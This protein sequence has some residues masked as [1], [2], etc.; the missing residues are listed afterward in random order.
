M[1]EYYCVECEKKWNQEKEDIAKGIN[2]P[3]TLH[4]E[5]YERLKENAGGDK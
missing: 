2:K 3:I 4:P 1:T 5:C